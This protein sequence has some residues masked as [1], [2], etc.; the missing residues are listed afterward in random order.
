M[1]LYGMLYIFFS[2]VLETFPISSSGHL[3]LLHRIFEKL[4]LPDFCNEAIDLFLHGP[5]ALVI[6]LFFF[7]DWCFFIQNFPRTLPLI[8]KIF[9]RGII[10]DGITVLVYFLFYKKIFFL[11]VWIGFLITSGLLF[12]LYYCNKKPPFAE[13]NCYNAMLLGIVQSIALIPGISRL[14]S[15][16][17]CARWMGLSMRRSFQLSFLIE[18]PISCAAFLK[19]TYSLYHENKIVEL[20]QLKVILVMIIA[21]VC[22]LCTLKL[23]ERMLHEQRE[24]IFSVYLVLVAMGS[25]LLV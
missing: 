18:W 21:I 9:L 20:L 10:T 23:V 25:F 8:K 3:E 4:D 2:I 5:I 24:W 19:G 7:N 22:G 12:S 11:P 16:F 6:A 1:S 13:W 14:G 15:T 17:V